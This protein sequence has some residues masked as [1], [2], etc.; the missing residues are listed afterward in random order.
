M[1]PRPH[2]ILSFSLIS[3]LSISLIDCN[4]SNPVSSGG[5]S[6]N[7][8]TDHTV[9][10]GGANHKPG[11]LNASTNCVSCHGSDLKGGSSPVSCYNCHGK[12][13]N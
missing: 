6:G 7:A 2:I 12:K 13:W 11:Y 3:L 9:S 5:G 10:F 1:N 4:Q 8:P